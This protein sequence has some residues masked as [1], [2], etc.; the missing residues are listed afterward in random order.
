LADRH[1]AAAFKQVIHVEFPA[2]PAEAATAIAA[3]A[4]VRGSGR[5]GRSAAGQAL[6]PQAVRAAVVAHIRHVHTEYDSLLM[7]G[8][9]RRAARERIRSRVQEVI[10]A[11]SRA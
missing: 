4:S 7:Q 5:V 1:F 10:D 3:H 2:C 11:W 9:E 8:V 6:D